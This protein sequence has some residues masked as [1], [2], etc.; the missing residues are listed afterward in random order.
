MRTQLQTPVLCPALCT[1]GKK[2][3]KKNPTSA[4]TPGLGTIP[5]TLCVPYQKGDASGGTGSV[6]CSPLPLSFADKTLTNVLMRISR[7]PEAIQS[8]LG[9][10]YCKQRQ[11][12]EPS[13][14]GRPQP[15]K[16]AKSLFRNLLLLPTPILHKGV[17]DLCSLQSNSLPAAFWSSCEQGSYP[18]CPFHPQSEKE[19]RQPPVLLT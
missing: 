18:V 6:P 19:L 10:R 5:K 11:V 8:L 12:P 17:D 15:A 13:Q 4:F 16:P 7:K 9:Q 1:T 2:E 3:R 14:E